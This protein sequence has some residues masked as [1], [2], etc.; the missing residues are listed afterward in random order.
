MKFLK[1]LFQISTLKAVAVILAA[2]GLTIPDSIIPA[3]STVALTAYGV[4][5]GLRDDTGDKKK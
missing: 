3:I 5:E 1:N 4:Y 2:F